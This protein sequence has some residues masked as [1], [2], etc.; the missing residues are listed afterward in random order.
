MPQLTGA[1]KIKDTWQVINSKLDASAYTSSD[2]IS[3]INGADVN[4]KSAKVSG[5]ITSNT[6][7]TSAG[8][9][10]KI[11]SAFIT[12][13]YKSANAIIDLLGG[14]AGDA[15]SVY[16]RIHFRV[17]Q[18]SAMG[19]API[20]ELE[21]ARDSVY[22][23]PNS[24][25]AT[26]AENTSSLT[27][28]DLYIKIT[29]PFDSVHFNPYMFWSS[30]DS[31]IQ[32][33]EGQPFVDALPGS[34]TYAKWLSWESGINSNGS[35]MRFA[36]G[37]QICW[38]SMTI[39]VTA[40]V[41]SEPTWVFPSAFIDGSSLIYASIGNVSTTRSYNVAILLTFGTTSWGTLVSLRTDV[42]QDYT[43]NL[44]AIGRWI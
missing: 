18:Q 33:L 23:D 1:E 12:E 37:T 7:G 44:L 22:L 17:K 11:A 6:G 41:A 31:T 42:S 26:I 39:T 24:V 16:A 38:S 13:Q 29:S 20:I 43:V 5:Y 3:K 40:G 28:V 36:D 19:T 30:G 10:T 34:V 27:Q 2:I 4:L 15:S 21:L 25:A 35:F 32:W 8:K 14:D 9:W